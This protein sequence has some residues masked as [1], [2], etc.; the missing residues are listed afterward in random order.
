M[1]K[2][3]FVFIVYASILSAQES[4]LKI[5]SFIISDE[6]G[7]DDP[8]DLKLGRYEAYEINIG[9]GDNLAVEL[10]SDDFWPVLLLMSPSKKPIIKFPIGNNRV[11]FD[12][13]I[14][15]GGTWELYV[16]GDTNSVGKYKCEIG[17]A[18]KE[19]LEIPKSQ[20]ECAEL[21]YFLSHA[22]A[23]FV[24]LR[25]KK[26]LNL[27]ANI[28]DIKFNEN[29]VSFSLDSG[30]TA[31]LESFKSKISKCL[32]S[33]WLIDSEDKRTGAFEVKF[34]ENTFKNRKYLTGSI[35]KKPGTSSY[36]ILI[37]RE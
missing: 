20:D 25:N 34:I 2:L 4:N 24:F 36:Q 21:N 14:T 26:N 17:F 15:E 28:S 6:L 29:R 11:I 9:K 22:E 13:T 23:N 16:M 19:A 30:G 27:F 5:S 35:N 31:S 8:V 18:E 33:G 7:F 10:S 3:I 32:G 37:G 12:T 1:R